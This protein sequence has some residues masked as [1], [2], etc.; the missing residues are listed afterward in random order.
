M[1]KTSHRFR[2]EKQKQV[3]AYSITRDGETCLVGQSRSAYCAT[4][5]DIHNNGDMTPVDRYPL[6]DEIHTEYGFMTRE[7]YLE[8][9]NG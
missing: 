3:F 9:K 6:G 5:N 1:A 2:Q 7:D 4:V 8:I